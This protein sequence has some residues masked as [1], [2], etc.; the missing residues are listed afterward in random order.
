M[1]VCLDIWIIP[2]QYLYHSTNTHIYCILHI[3]YYSRAHEVHD[4]RQ[5][6]I[7]PHGTLKGNHLLIG[8]LAAA[9]AL[10]S[11][12]RSIEDTFCILHTHAQAT[13]I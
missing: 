12:L 1:V 3:T 9:R 11:K 8:M 4:Y 6:G 13:L 2:H 10:L 7:N 5:S